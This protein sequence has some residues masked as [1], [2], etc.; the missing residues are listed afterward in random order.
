MCKHLVDENTA[1]CEFKMFRG[2]ELGMGDF[3]G[4]EL[5]FQ[6]ALP[7]PEEFREDG[8]FGC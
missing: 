5:A 6:F 7:E 4:V 8:E 2:D 1:L 3:D